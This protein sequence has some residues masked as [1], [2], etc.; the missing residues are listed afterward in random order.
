MDE[1]SIY[2]YPME[3][4]VN[5]DTNIKDQ[6]PVKQYD[7]TLDAVRYVIYALKQSCKILAG[8]NRHRKP[9][10]LDLRTHAADHLL[11]RNVED[12]DW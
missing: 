9:E 12:Y 8:D 4:D 3:K 7:H 2:H 10:K 6:L 1:I 11:L 5:A